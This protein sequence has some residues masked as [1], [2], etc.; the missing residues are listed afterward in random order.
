[1]SSY[2]LGCICLKAVFTYKNFVLIPHFLLKNY[3]EPDTK[4]AD[5]LFKAGLQA[6]RKLIKW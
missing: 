3:R 4:L 1:M 5:K 6:G 2:I